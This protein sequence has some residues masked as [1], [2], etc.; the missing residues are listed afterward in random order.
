MNINWQYYQA[1]YKE[2]IEEIPHQLQYL[3]ST[4]DSSEDIEYFLYNELS[5]NIKHQ[6]KIYNI[7]EPIIEFME[8]NI[9]QKRKIQYKIEILNFLGYIFQEYIRDENC[10]LVP[11]IE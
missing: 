10:I 4:E 2:A 6:Y 7:I 11:P 5:P 1:P 3:F 8:F 9:L